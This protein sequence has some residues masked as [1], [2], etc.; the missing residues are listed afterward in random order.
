M[1]KSSPRFQQAGWPNSWVRIYP[2]KSK[3]WWKTDSL[4]SCTPLFYSP[5]NLQTKV[6]FQ[7]W[8]RQCGVCLEGSV[9]MLLPQS[10]PSLSLPSPFFPFILPSPESVLKS[11]AGDGRGGKKESFQQQGMGKGQKWN[12]PS[13]ISYLALPA[14]TQKQVRAVLLPQWPWLW[15]AENQPSDWAAPATQASS[16]FSA[17]FAKEQ[18]QHE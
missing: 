15:M 12:P 4:G 10:L 3:G 11:G 13:G 7:L 18:R 2:P 1:V 9:L 8:G 16:P 6:Y 14:G 17:T 5:L